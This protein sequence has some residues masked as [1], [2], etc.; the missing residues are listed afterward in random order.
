MLAD[1]NLHN[2]RRAGRQNESK[3]DFLH[4]SISY[5]HYVLNSQNQSQTHNP[6]RH[7]VQKIHLDPHSQCSKI[8][9]SGISIPQKTVTET[10]S[11]INDRKKDDPMM[12]RK[13]AGLTERYASL[14]WNEVF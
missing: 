10:G 12:G 6:I 2:G 5:T 4:N 11:C 8:Q 13:H 1:Q 3:V 9:L 14:T 7:S